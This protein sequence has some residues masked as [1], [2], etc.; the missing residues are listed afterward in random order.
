MIDETKYTPEE[1][2]I[3]KEFDYRCAVCGAPAVTLHEIVPKSKR[4]KTWNKP[5]NRIPLCND[6]HLYAHAKGTK[7]VQDVLR[8]LRYHS[9]Y[10]IRRS[11]SG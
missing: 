9:R 1:I 7:R 4:P 11:H 3:F 2:E 10:F 6:H 8:N 5:E